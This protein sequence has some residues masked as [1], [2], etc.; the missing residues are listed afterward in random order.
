MNKTYF[1][2]GGASLAS[3]AIGGAGGYL[4][5]RKTITD[6]VEDRIAEEVDK[7]KAYYAVLMAHVATSP[8]NYTVKDIDEEVVAEDIEPEVEEEELSEADKRVITNGQ[9]ALVN[10]Q[11]YAEK[12][13]LSSLVE[14]NIFSKNMPKKQLP[15][16]DPTGKFLPKSAQPE[17]STPEETPYMI[18]QE[19]Y[20]TNDMDHNQETLM[21]FGNDSTLIAVADN[22]SVDINC[23]GEVNLT[24]FPE[25]PEGTA[26]FIYVRNEGL[27]ID[28]EIQLT[29]ESLSEYMGL[30]GD[31]VDES[32]SDLL[33]QN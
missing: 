22:T 13:A 25:E 31:E 1:L 6:Q 30:G 27:G 24:L 23:V 33:Y 9:K 14:N 29:D 21:Y 16:R 17:N 26:R 12:P 20:L 8:E 18:P 11:G 3:L 10:Y 32:E 15:P 28:Y 4:Y 2:V 5:A 19:E 7:A